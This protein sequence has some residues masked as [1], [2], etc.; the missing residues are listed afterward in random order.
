MKTT[1]LLLK[2]LYPPFCVICGE[3]LPIDRAEEALCEKCLP[4]WQ[5]AKLARCPDCHRREDEC[6]CTPNTLRRLA[7]ECAHLIAY[8]ESANAAEKLLLTAK[9]ERYR[10]LFCFLGKELSA[11]FDA[12]VPSVERDALVTWMP[13]SR[14]RAADS[15]VDQAKEIAKAFASLR[16]FETAPLFIRV[17]GGAQKA[18][19]AS[20]R[21]EHARET[22][23]L[24]PKHSPLTGRTV[25]LID[26]IFTTG[27]TMLA[28]TEL[29]HSAG[30]G[31]VICL[32]VAKTR[33]DPPKHT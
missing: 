18:L 10:S 5:R 1:D 24:K 27:A 7:A 31:R 11:R 30:A 2:L 17:R 3:L 32:T 19:T 6:R 29:L 25:I 21:F 22:Y 28:A 4:K 9:D 8:R 14:L 20:E 12:I 33:N 26:D 13:R 15:G 16:S 23:R